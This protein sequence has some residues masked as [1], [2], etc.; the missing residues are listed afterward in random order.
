MRF[1]PTVD[2]L[3]VGLV[4][5][6]I[7]VECATTCA[8]ARM[9]GPAEWI[10]G[11]MVEIPGGSF[12]MG[13]DDAT[14]SD[15]QKPVHA[16]AVASFRLDKTEVTV[17]AYGECV[18]AGRC[19]EPEAYLDERGNYRSFCNW[20]HPQGRLAHPV[21]CVDFQQAAKFCAWAGKRL[22]TEEEWEYAARGRRRGQEIS[23]GKRRT[24]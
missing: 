16:V 13:C 5:V 23:L 8:T 4:M 18:R 2:A 21:N 12:A 24:E 3:A 7:G 1:S 15:S 6:L 9:S 17:E 19:G 14:A 22:P 10:R 11:N 20:R